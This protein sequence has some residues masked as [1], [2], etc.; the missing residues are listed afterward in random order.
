M[1]HPAGMRGLKHVCLLYIPGIRKV[2]SRRDAWIETLYYGSIRKPLVVA[3]RRDAWI[4]TF[5]LREIYSEEGSHPA[6]MRGLKLLKVN[7]PSE[8]ELVA[9]RRDA[10]IETI[11]FVCLFDFA[12]GRIP[13]GCVD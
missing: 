4:E 12:V 7:I 6:G 3:S 13:Q 10:W 5:Y 8:S 9:S 11:S 1:S 2:A